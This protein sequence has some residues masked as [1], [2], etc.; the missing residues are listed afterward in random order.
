ME[1]ARDIILLGIDGGGTRCRARLAD[2]N[3]TILAE[4]FGGPANLRL[5]LDDSVRVVR[6]CT[7]QCVR[8]ASL[9]GLERKIIACL[10]LAGASEPERLAAAQR[11]R[12]P[13][14]SA[15]I[16]TDARAACIGAHN[17][18]DG[19]IV[20]AGTGSIGWASLGGR[21]YRVGGWGFPLSDEGSGAWIGFAAL[22]RLLRAHDGLRDWT[23]LLRALFERFDGNPH[24]IVQWMDHAR[25]AE[26]AELAPMVIAHVQYGDLVAMDVLSRAAAH[27]EALARRLDAFGVTRLCLMGGLASSIEPFL[28]ITRR[29]ALAPAMGDALSGALHL[30]RSEAHRAAGLRPEVA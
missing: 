27:V 3:G 24:N 12:Y 26:Y 20:I 16:T 23:E 22:K 10:A 11:V 15:L 8:Q 21:Q 25:P 30:A 14:R 28:P 1:L 7:G 9:S 6:E 17:G 5:G 2:A 29:N 18:G 19:G 13:F 4:C